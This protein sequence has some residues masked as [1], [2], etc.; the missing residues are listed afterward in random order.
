MLFIKN[1]SKKNFSTITRGIIDLEKLKL[2]VNSLLKYLEF[3]KP[4]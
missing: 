2:K 1:S 4:N 3:R